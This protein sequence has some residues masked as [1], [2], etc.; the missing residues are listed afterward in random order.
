MHTSYNKIKVIQQRDDLDKF[1]DEV[2]DPD[3]EKVCLQH[4]ELRGV[5]ESGLTLGTLYGVTLFIKRFEYSALA[6]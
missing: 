2:V 4:E 1:L 5:V 6:Q 3:H